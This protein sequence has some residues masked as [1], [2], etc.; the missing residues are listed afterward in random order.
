MKVSIVIPVYNDPR[1]RAALDSI[2]DQQYDGD[3]EVLV[4]D[5]GSTDDTLDI[6][7]GYGGL[8]SVLVSEPDQ[9]IFDAL[10]KG[11]ERAT[12]DVIA[13]LGADDRYEDADVVRDALVPLRDESVDASYGDLVYVDD[14]DKVVRYWRSGPFLRRKLYFGWMPPHFTLFA[15]RRVYERVGLFD[16][17]NRVAADYDHMLRA[18][19]QHRIKV[20]YVDRVLLRMTLGG[21]SNNSLRNI[22]TGN[23]ESFRAWKK[24]NAVMGLLVPVLKPASKLLQLVRRPPSN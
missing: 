1:I 5:G 22:V 24:H 18:F 7:R 10:N 9:G 11:I 17:T 15:R 13:L 16:V 6:V 14:N 8:V 3:V 4:I 20:A 21:N 2:K 19:L 23:M 12:G